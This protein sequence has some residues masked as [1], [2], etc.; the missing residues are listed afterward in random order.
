LTDTSRNEH[1]RGMSDYQMNIKRV[2]STQKALNP[3]KESKSKNYFT[4]LTESKDKI[5]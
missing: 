4:N 5:S 1:E 2:I 3:I